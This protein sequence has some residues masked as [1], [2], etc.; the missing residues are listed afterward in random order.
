MVDPERWTVPNLPTR[1]P[2]TLALLVDGGL[3]RRIFRGDKAPPAPEIIEDEAKLWRDGSA[4]F[5]AQCA[6]C[7]GD[8]GKEES[9]PG[10]KSLSGIGNRHSEEEIFELTQRAGFVDLSS[11]DDR[12]RR[13]LSVFVAGL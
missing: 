13:A 9:Y 10:T 7:H 2:R 3:I 6:R 4:I 12:A 11:L 8:D 5:K 1:G